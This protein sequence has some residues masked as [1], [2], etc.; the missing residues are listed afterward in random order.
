M[1]SLDG[2]RVEST[3]R[4]MAEDAMDE[5]KPSRA[6]RVVLGQPAAKAPALDPDLLVIHHPL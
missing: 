5:A 3:K 1:M 2:V 6:M 4:I